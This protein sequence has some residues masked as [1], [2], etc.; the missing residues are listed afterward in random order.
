MR[1]EKYLK[2]ILGPSF[3]VLKFFHFNVFISF[4]KAHGLS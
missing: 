3:D 2:Q 4:L 1:L